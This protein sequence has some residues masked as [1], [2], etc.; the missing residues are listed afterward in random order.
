ML[1]EKY[2]KIPLDKYERFKGGNNFLF[3]VAGPQTPQPS[4]LSNNQNKKADNENIVVKISILKIYKLYFFY[5]NQE[6][7][8]G[9]KE[10]A[11]GTN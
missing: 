2:E 5:F 6:K 10:N 4:V 9:S 3:S 11:Q 8:S 7:I 1:T